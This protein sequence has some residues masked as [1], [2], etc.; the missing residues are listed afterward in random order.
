MSP[1]NDPKGR[2]KISVT[3]PVY[4]EASNVVRAIDAVEK[5]FNQ[6]LSRFELEIVIT[7]NASTDGTWQTVANL[8]RVRS[9]LTG[10]RFSRNFGYQN[11]VFAG[12]ALAT[13]DAVIEMDADLEDPPE[14]IP[15]FVKQWE[16]GFEVVYGVRSKRHGPWWMRAMFAAFYHALNRLSE[17]PIPR[18]A[19]DFRLLDR[20][21]VDRLRAL[22]E[23]NLY[24]R[25]L[26][27]YL[28]FK[29]IPVAYERQP[30]LS[31]S[32][33]FRFLHYVALAIDAIT[34]FTKAP[35]RL[36]G[37]L[38]FMLFALALGASL[39]YLA[40]YFKY[41]TPIQ[42]FTTL[43]ILMLLLNSI[44]FMFLGIIGEYLSRIF[45]DAKMRP[46]VVI[47]ESTSSAPYPREL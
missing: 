12:L 39:Y 38:G 35:L 40:T 16:E 26:V 34:A 33:K 11:S 10:Y 9:H 23:R 5:V 14:V 37:V 13:G 27:V 6:E 44:T 43:V 42:G 24:L 21:V 41:G 7:D 22:P 4:N 32:S 18:N 47:S 2:K 17:L 19:G 45:D 36:I 20:R 1:T 25:G 28:G 31:G 30:R 46:R 8:A 15:E 29:Q 3:I